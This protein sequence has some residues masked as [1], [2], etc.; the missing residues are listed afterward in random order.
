M[1]DVPELPPRRILVCGGRHYSDSK[2]LWGVLSG[3][4]RETEVSCI[5]SGGAEG[6]DT[7]AV[8]WADF[9]EIP[10]AVFPAKWTE[11]GRSAGPIRNSKMLVE[12]KPDLIV[13]FPGGAG[14]ADMVR[15]AQKAGIR[16]MDL[17]D[18]PE[19]E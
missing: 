15:K 8:E 3:L 1:T 10:Y 19:A 9:N 16:V 12:G 5:I 17:R 18:A 11:H 13:A 6:A 4:L 7:M 2:H 14:T